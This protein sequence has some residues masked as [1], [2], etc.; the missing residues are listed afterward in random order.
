MATNK[1]IHKLIYYFLLIMPFIDLFSSIATWNNWPSIGL[2]FKGIFL[3]FAILFLVKNEKKCWKYFIAITIYSII[4]LWINSQNGSLFQEVSNLI[5]IFYL[6]TL[7]LYFSNALNPYLNS[8]LITQISVLYLLLYLIPYPFNL[9]HNISE[10]YPNKNLYLSYFYIGNELANIFI[11]LIPIAFT[12][13]YEQ[14]K[15][16]NLILY[17]LLVLSMLALL[18]TKTMYLSVILIVLF[19]LYVNRQKV[20]STIKKHRSI[21]LTGFIIGIVGTVIILPK[22]AFYQNISTSL[23]YY[24]I[25]SIGELISIENI[26]N[27]IYSNRLDFLANIHQEYIKSPL[28]NQFFGIGRSKILASKDIEIDIFDIFYSIGIIGFV[29]YIFYSIFALRQKKLSMLYKF[30]LILLI[31]IS[32]FSGHVLISPMVSTYLALLYGLNEEKK[33]AKE[34][35]TVDQRPI[36]KIKN[37]FNA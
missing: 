23:D 31:I 2:A 34:N 16:R 1:K 28:I 18:G 24:K 4:S 3:L 32:L 7:I 19:F 17:S 12:Y 15:K 5:K 27:I 9:G 36:K 20:L 11:L 13:L 26:D 35:E 22:T 29:L 14:K 33:G 30:L 6:P 25:S 37:R 21:F 10:I 8:K